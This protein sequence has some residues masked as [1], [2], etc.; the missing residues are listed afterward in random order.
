MRCAEKLEPPQKAKSTKLD[1]FNSS[2]THAGPR[3][4]SAPAPAAAAANGGLTAAESRATGV[5]SGEV[6][7]AYARAMGG[8]PVFLQL[9]TLYIFI[10]VLRNAASVWLGVWTAQADTVD[11]GSS[12]PPPATVLLGAWDVLLLAAH[13]AASKQA[14]FYLAVF[15]AISFA[16]VRRAVGCDSLSARDHSHCVEP[17]WCRP[18]NEAAPHGTGLSTQHALIVA[19]TGR[20]ESSA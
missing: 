6:L 14:L 12:S 10:E 11:G 16:Q 15:C 19:Y 4:P 8:L 5:V 3:G 13:K 1:R 2:P 20:C 7:M 18:C 17:N 9:V